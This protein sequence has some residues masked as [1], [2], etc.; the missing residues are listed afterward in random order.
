MSPLLALGIAA[1]V[2]LPVAT[3]AMAMRHAAAPNNV[4]GIAAHDAA[5]FDN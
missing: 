2:V 1:L 5:P 4:R 3:F